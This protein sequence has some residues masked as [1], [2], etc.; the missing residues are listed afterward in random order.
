MRGQSTQA[1]DPPSPGRKSSMGTGCKPLRFTNEMCDFMEGKKNNCWDISPIF[2]YCSALVDSGILTMA[3]TS[4]APIGEATMDVSMPVLLHEP[5]SYSL[6]TYRCAMEVIAFLS[7]VLMPPSTKFPVH[8]ET[9]WIFIQPQ[10]VPEI[11]SRFHPIPRFCEGLRCMV[12]LFACA[13][14]LAPCR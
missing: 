1:L 12:F 8:H 13:S 10:T 4:V 3:A 2:I 6:E 7:W 5:S 9:S 11:L 14:L